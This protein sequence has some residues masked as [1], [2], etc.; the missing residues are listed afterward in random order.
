MLG[1]FQGLLAPVLKAAEPVLRAAEPVREAL[2]IHADTYAQVGAVLGLQ[3]DTYS[4]VGEDCNLVFDYGTSELAVDTERIQG[5]HLSLGVE[6]LATLP[7]ELMASVPEHFT[8]EDI[9]ERKPFKM[10]GPHGPIEVKPPEGTVKGGKIKMRLVPR[11]EFRIEVPQDSRP[12]LCFNV[13]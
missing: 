6:T 12:G 8:E 13:K 11:P 2:G 3:H 1:S 10:R 7:V 4:Q 9:K 5:P